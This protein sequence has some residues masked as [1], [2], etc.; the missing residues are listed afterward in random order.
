MRAHETSDDWS[1]LFTS[2]SPCP[3]VR[4]ILLA[5][6]ECLPFT[7]SHSFFGRCNCRIYSR[8]DNSHKGVEVEFGWQKKTRKQNET[9]GNRTPDFLRRVSS[10]LK[11]TLRTSI[12][13]VKSQPQSLT[14]LIGMPY[15]PLIMK[16]SSEEIGFLLRPVLFQI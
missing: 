10:V 6:G 12:G 15:I 1:C 9:A 4:C 16:C 11:G 5:S 14:L 3:H 8:E 7:G 13:Q 2:I